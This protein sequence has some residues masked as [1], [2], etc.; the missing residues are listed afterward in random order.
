MEVK[1]EVKIKKKIESEEKVKVINPNDY[2]DY[3]D[4]LKAR[5]QNE[6]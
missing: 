6:S 5:R 3:G 1:K 2:S 4:Y